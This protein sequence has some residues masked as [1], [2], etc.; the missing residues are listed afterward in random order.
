ML[1]GEVL[2]A[3]NQEDQATA[4][5]EAAVKASPR[6]PE[7]HFGLGYLY[8]KRKRYEDACREF[9]AELANRPQDTQA[10]AYLGDAEMHAGKE[11]EAEEHLRR[12]LKLDASF[13]LAQLD[14]G[15]LLASKNDS[16]GAERHFREAIRIDPSKPDAHYHLGRLLRSLGRKQEAD[17]EFAKVKELAKEEQQEPLIKV[18]GR[19]SEPAP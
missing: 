14:L 7:V 6:E 15:I 13:R 16:I 10:L 11:K 19:R 18:P 4:E 17:S 2:D 5:F 1:L 8:W 12:A 3:A 9:Q